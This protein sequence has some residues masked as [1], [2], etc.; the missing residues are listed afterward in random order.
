MKTKIV[1]FFLLFLNTVLYAQYRFSSQNIHNSVLEAIN[2]NN[3][4][5]KGRTKYFE[6]KSEEKPLMFLREQKNVSELNRV[7]NS[8]SNYINKLKTE[9]DTE[10]ILYELID[11]DFFKELLFTASGKLTLKGKVLKRK[12]DSLHL[13]N[14]K[15]N[16]RGFT[17]L[18]QFSEEHF[19]TDAEYYNED[20]SNSDFFNHYFY[21]KSNYGIMMSLNLLLLDVTTNQLLFF[22]TIMTY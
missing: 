10:K 5:I 11:E 14:N 20:G 17:H 15:I 13:I 12:L 2:V 19:K 1:L 8:V 21:D 9:A 16:L 4:V 3:D 18:K 6:D 22:G 7:S